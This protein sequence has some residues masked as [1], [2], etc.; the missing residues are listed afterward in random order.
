MHNA[1]VY[2]ILNLVHK[3]E[4][5]GLMEAGGIWIARWMKK[6]TFASK[7]K[8]LENTEIFN[9]SSPTQLIIHERKKISNKKNI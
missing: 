9:S 5:V 4:W 7:K 6:I 8:L 3:T 2:Y 1:M